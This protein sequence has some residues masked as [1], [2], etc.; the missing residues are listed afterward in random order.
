MPLDWN[1]AASWKILALI[2]SSVKTN[3]VFPKYQSTRLV[4]EYSCQR[5]GF[6]LLR[7][8]LSE[9]FF[10]FS[11]GNGCTQG[12]DNAVWGKFKKPC[13]SGSDY[14]KHVPSL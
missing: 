6:L 3:D 2:G 10:P 4:F 14:I 7:I 8:A 1:L 12:G 13:A 11:C 9:S 5:S